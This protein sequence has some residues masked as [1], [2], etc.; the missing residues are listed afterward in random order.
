MVIDKN[1]IYIGIAVIG[2]ILAGLVYVMGPG[3]GRNEG[4]LVSATAEL[5]TVSFNVEP[6]EAEA[7]FHQSS[8]DGYEQVLSEA[9]IIR[10]FISGEIYQPDVYDISSDARVVDLLNMAG[11]ATV[12]ADLNRVN[13][14]AFLEDAS[15]II[16]PAIGEEFP[17]GFEDATTGTSVVGDVATGLI[18]INN[19]S[20]TELTQLPGIGPV[21]SQNIVNHREQNGNFRSIEEIQNV[22]RIGTAV[23]ENIRHLITVD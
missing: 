23:F 15:H 11:G 4:Y 2:V 5:P 13:L 6:Y 18:N 12:Y 9:T 3:S 20:A 7:Y 8:A 21:I 14:A 10:V 19:A 17:E 1:K 22:T 16:I